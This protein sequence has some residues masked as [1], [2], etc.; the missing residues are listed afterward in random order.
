MR[1]FEASLQQ[2]ADFLLKANLVTEKAAPC[3]VRWVRRFVSRPASNEPLADQVRRF[4]EELQKAGACQDWQLRQAE[5]ALRIRFVNYLQRTDWHRQPQSALV[6]EQGRT[7]PLAALD[8]TPVT[9]PNATLLLPN[10]MQLRGLGPSILLPPSLTR[11]A[12][13]P[14]SWQPSSTAAACA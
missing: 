7:S 6:D 9:H 2:F 10:R 14:G 5:Q 13:R 8:E 12:A 3:C 4:C 1:E 11:C